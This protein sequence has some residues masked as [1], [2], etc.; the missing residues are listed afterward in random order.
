M[1]ESRSKIGHVLAKG[2]GIKLQKDE[3]YEEEV[4]RGESAFSVHTGE[5]F[6]EPRPTT[7]E[8]LLGGTPKGKDVTAYI[9]SLFPFL[10][11]ITRY[12]WL[13]AVGDIVAGS[14]PP[15]DDLRRPG[16]AAHSFRR[17]HHRCR[18]RAPGHG[19]RAAGQPRAPVWPLLVLYGRIDLLVLRHLEGYHHRRKLP[20]PCANSGTQRRCADFG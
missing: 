18:R 14:F 12:N 7:A 16:C 20:P 11:W 9:W 15:Y 2:L 3:P 1:A 4:T 5:S 10:H 17:R 19:V 8:F 13:W 6:I